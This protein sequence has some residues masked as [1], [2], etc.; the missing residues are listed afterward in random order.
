MFAVGLT[1]PA[2]GGGSRIGTARAGV[3]CTHLQGEI[4]TASNV[5]QDG[6]G[7]EVPHGGLR[8]S[9]NHCAALVLDVDRRLWSHPPRQFCVE[10]RGDLTP[11]RSPCDGPGRWQDVI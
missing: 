11:A 2:V 5:E 9:T 7:L 1:N 10:E 3:H 8:A 6:G 4:T